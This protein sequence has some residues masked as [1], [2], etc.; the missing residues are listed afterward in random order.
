MSKTL[1]CQTGDHDWIHPGGRGRPPVNCPEHSV[2]TKQTREPLAKVNA[3]TKYSITSKPPKPGPDDVPIN[4]HPESPRHQ[5]NRELQAKQAAAK[6]NLFLQKAKK[7]AIG[8]RLQNGKAVAKVERTQKENNAI[9][10]EY[11]AIDERIEKADK[12]YEES[13]NATQAAKSKE[14]IDKAFKFSDAKQSALLNLLA[15]KR[16][17]EAM[18]DQMTA[19]TGTDNI[20]ARNDQWVDSSSGEVLGS[21]TVS[22]DDLSAAWEGP[23][24]EIPEQTESDLGDDFAA[25]IAAELGN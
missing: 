8:E 19:P 16:K 25:I 11:L 23:D 24:A 22:L 17:L 6:P 18:V 15:R 2:A 20:I 21:T 14:E 1:H 3:K 9:E 7:K 5:A 4:R 13:L 12:A 10:A